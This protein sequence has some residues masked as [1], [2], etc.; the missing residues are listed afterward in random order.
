MSSEVVA[1]DNPEVIIAGFGRV[2]QII[3]RVLYANQIRAT[4][5]DH[6][7]DQIEQLR[8]FGFKVYYGDA[9]RLDLLEAAG[10]RKARLL[11]NA[12]DDVEDSL[13][14][15]DRARANF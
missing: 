11:V 4:V 7:P 5:L 12:I 8:K 6:D 15:V 10:A 9:T 13:A 2:G 3:G 1:N 14:L